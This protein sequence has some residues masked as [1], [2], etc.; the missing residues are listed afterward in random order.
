MISLRQYL[1]VDNVK[2]RGNIK[3]L[4]PYLVKGNKKITEINGG[5]KFNN[6]YKTD[7]TG[8]SKTGYYGNESGDI[9]NAEQIQEL[10]KRVKNQGITIHNVIFENLNCQGMSE[11]ELKN[12]RF[13]LDLIQNIE[14]RSSNTDLTNISFKDASH[15]GKAVFTETSDRYER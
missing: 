11:E 4:L 7:C 1:I 10:H 15:L 5:I 6:R 14:F 12:T 13:T 8:V 2:L 9:L 3:N